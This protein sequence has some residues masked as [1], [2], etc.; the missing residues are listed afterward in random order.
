[1]NYLYWQEISFF[2]NEL[3][4]ERGVFEKSPMHTEDMDRSRDKMTNTLETLR[5]GLEQRMDKYQA[6]LVLFPIVAALD[7]KMQAYDYNSNK[8]KWAP[9]QK[10]FFSS[11]NAGEIFFKS[12]DDILD[13][14]NIPNIVFQV[15]YAMLKRGFQGKYKDSKTQIA[16]YLDMLKD[17]VPVFIP[18]KKKA[19]A[20]HTLETQKKS[21]IKKWHCYSLSFALFAVTFGCLKLF[22]KFQ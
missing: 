13:D 18:P 14:P 7:E 16:K 6:S 4:K 1:M 5:S 15:Y 12:L 2:L 3:D 9:L 20:Q 22:A 21:W 17:K 11:Y 19:A 8:I 10:D